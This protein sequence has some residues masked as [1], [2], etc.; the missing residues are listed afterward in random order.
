MRSSEDADLQTIFLVS[1]RTV[2]PCPFARDISLESFR[3]ITRDA[4]MH[5][6]T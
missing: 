4:S 6:E 1:Y 2:E 5:H 3:I